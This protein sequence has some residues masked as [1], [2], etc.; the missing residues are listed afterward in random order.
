MFEKINQEINKAWDY[1]KSKENIWNQYHDLKLHDAFYEAEDIVAR[2]P[3][4]KEFNWMDLFYDFCEQEYSAFLEDMERNAIED[5]RK[6]IERT[7]KFYLTDIHHNNPVIVI[8][9]I[10]EGINNGYGTAYIEFRQ[11]DSGKIEAFIDFD[12]WKRYGCTA[13][14]VLRD[15]AEEMEYF[16]SGEFLTDVKH[17]LVDAEYIYD[18]IQWI[19][20]HQVEFFT[21]WIAEGEAV[22]AEAEAEWQEKAYIEA[23]KADVDNAAC[24]LTMIA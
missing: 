21:D 1:L 19:K 9:N 8:H 5:V 11:A 12:G 20:K 17:F 4:M 6:Y 15:A 14:N 2:Y 10:Y 24:L 23:E 13:E 22:E 16:A 7:S 18:Y 3:H